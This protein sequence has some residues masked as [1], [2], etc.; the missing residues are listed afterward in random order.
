MILPMS[1]PEAIGVASDYHELH[2]ILRARAEALNISREQLDEIAGLPAGYSA[3]LLAMEPVRGMGKMSLGA[4]L[5]S[6]GLTLIVVEDQLALTRYAAR[7]NQRSTRQVRLGN[8]NRHN[9]AAVE[10]P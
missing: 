1:I 9:A 4:L 2:A 5:A 7:A 6:L 8:R 3:K 10:T